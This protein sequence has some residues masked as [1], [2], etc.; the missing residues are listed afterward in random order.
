MVRAPACSYP[1][2]SIK[3]RCRQRAALS[4]QLADYPD[5]FTIHF[6]RNAEGSVFR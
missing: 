5:I 2:R 4:G 6:S 1:C 3:R